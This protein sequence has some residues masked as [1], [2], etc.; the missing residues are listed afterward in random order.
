MRKTST[1]LSSTLSASAPRTPRF[2][3]SESDGTGQPVRGDQ[4]SGCTSLI[5]DQGDKGTTRHTGCFMLCT[6]SIIE[7]NQHY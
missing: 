4:T 6:F 2:A 3:V 7:C 1:C 5:S